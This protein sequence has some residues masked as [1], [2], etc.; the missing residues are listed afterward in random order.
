[1][2]DPGNAPG[3]VID[4]VAISAIGAN[5]A[6]GMQGCAECGVKIEE[7]KDFRIA[8]DGGIVCIPCR[9]KEVAR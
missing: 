2:D 8:T 1:M 3:W 9:R 5:M 6:L 7:P 4:D